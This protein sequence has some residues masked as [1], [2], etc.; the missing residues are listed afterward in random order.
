MNRWLLLL[1]AVLLAGC[2]SSSAPFTA[3]SSQ[4]A[5]VRWSKPD[6]TLVCEAVF[7][8]S[9]E[10]AVR[11]QLYKGTPKVLVTFSLDANKKMSASGP[12]AGFGWRGNATAAPLPLSTWSRFLLDYQAT[13]TWPDGD[14]E[15]HSGDSRTA[16]SIVKHQAR[17]LS[18]SNNLSGETITA[19]FRAP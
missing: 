7:S 8:R 9:S 4:Q 16:V 10:S 18:V 13:P 6:N 3:A 12:M 19:K 1:A 15:I 5:L 14:N 17:T 2:A 11:V